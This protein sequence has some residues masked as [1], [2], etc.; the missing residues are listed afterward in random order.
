MTHVKTLLA[1]LVFGLFFTG[2]SQAHTPLFSCYDNGDGSVTCEG[3]FPTDPP[4]PVSRSGW[5]IRT[6]RY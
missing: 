5:R 2:I 6:E 1:I 4:P 3:G